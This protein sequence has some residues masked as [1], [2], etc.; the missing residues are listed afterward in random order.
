MIS[1]LILT[2]GNFHVSNRQISS[3]RIE[4]ITGHFCFVN[5]N[6]IITIRSLVFVIKTKSMHDLNWVALCWL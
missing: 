4:T 6:K 1:Y 5:M 2:F 3:K